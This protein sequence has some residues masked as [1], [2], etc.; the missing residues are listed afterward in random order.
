MSA[1]EKKTICV[2]M[3]VKNETAVIRRCLDSVRPI[4]DYWV[5]VD[6]GSTDGTQDMIREH[7]KDV[8]GELFE[9]PWKNFAHNRNEALELARGKADYILIIDADDTLRFDPSFKLP[10]LTKDGY[11]IWIEHGNTRYNRYQLIRSK[12]PWKW[13]G[14]LHEVLTCPPPYT[15]DVLENVKYVFGG[16]GARSQDPAKYLRDA[17]ILEEAV[18]EDPSNTRYT[19][20]LAQSYRDADLKEKSIEWYQK[21]IAM[22]GWPEEVY[23]SMLQ[24]A[25]LKSSLKTVSEEEVIECFYRAHRYRPHRYEPIYYLAEIFNK[26][27]RFELAYSLVKSH[28]FIPQPKN[29]DVLFTQEWIEN[30]GLLFQVSIC[31][32]YLGHYQESLDACDTLLKME[33]LP[34]SFR[35]RT[36]SNREFSRKKL[37]EQSMANGCPALAPAA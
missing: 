29:K 10:P 37:E 6:T 24:V 36:I 14:V 5:I 11:R 27:G 32:Y 26:N 16:D 17:K 18:K 22:G 30:Y 31:S 2:N 13:E 12:S 21:R 1:E 7:M 8:P 25:K 33:K 3:I 19:F 15:Q 4:I 35:S 34:E 23:W 9:R 28:S 20:Y